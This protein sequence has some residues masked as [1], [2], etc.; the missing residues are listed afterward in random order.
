MPT[1]DFQTAT[2]QSCAP[3]LKREGLIYPRGC[4]TSIINLCCWQHT[5]HTAIAG[6]QGNYAARFLLDG[7]YTYSL[8]FKPEDLP[9]MVEMVK[10]D[11]AAHGDP[12]VIMG[13]NEEMLPYYLQTF[14]KRFIA[15][16]N[17][18]SSDY[19]YDRTALSTL[20]GHKL[21]SK[22]NFLNRFRRTYPNYE[23]RA[24][25]CED[26]PACLALDKSW[27]NKGL[28]L[29]HTQEEKDERVA[30]HYVFDHWQELQ[31]LG[32]VI[33]VDGALVAFTYGAPIDDSRFD[34]CVEKADSNYVGSY[35]AINNE[36]VNHL[37]TNFA[38]INR[39]E[40]LGI[41]GLRQAKQTYQPLIWLRKYT[42][43]E[44]QP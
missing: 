27:I 2:P 30:I 34:V 44:N 1:L 28:D 26:I 36:F 18:D 20:A 38:L 33:Y 17:D 19:V 22:R 14:P 40:D 6:W 12:L 10:A 13:V 42:L 32:G 25:T 8:R 35:A 4:D 21:Q 39:E 31:A 9:Q 7:H 15:E 37:P 41:P 24:L 5:Y 3:L 29:G 43:T 11:A 23:Y 16:Y